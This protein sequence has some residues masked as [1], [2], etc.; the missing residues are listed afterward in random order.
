[1]RSLIFR[2]LALVVAA[3][4]VPALAI[5]PNVAGA[6]GAGLLPTNTYCNLPQAD[7]TIP[8][9]KYLYAF[10]WNGI[11]SAHGEL[12]VSLDGTHESEQYCFA[13]TASTSGIVDALWKFRAHATAIVDGSTGRAT[14][15]HVFQQ[16]NTRIR[17]TETLFDYETS[18]AHYTRW[19]RDRVRRKTITLGDDII[20]PVSLGLIICEQ[21]LR[22][23]DVTVVTV[24]FGDDR[25]ALEY[26]VCARERVSLGDREVEALR[27]EPKFHKIEDEKKGKPPKVKE[28]TLWLSDSQPRIPLLMKSRT[29]VGS[30]TGELVRMIA[31]G[32]AEGN[33]APAS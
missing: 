21:P 28:M 13:A 25:Y 16:E 15:I 29:F 14:K 9:G 4:L 23:G 27:I 19:K 30:V 20:D 33:S 3:V 26:E 5:Q 6:N 11:P 24:L 1:M 17:E 12:V 31:A 2:S 7:F 32:D 22:V 8:E 18:W 10:S